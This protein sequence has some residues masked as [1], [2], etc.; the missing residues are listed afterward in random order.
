[1]KSIIAFYTRTGNTKKVAELIEKQ[2]NADTEE[3]IDKKN[4]SGFFGWLKSGYHATMGKTTEI[5]E[6][7]SD[8]SQYDIIIL[9]TPNWNK[10]MT[11]AIRTYINRF[12]EDFKNV[13]IYCTAEGRGVDSLLGD[14][15]E[16]IGKEPIAKMGFIKKD[17]EENVLDIKIKE[18]TEKIQ[19]SMKVD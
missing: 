17:A 19:N 5:G 8:P 6:L 15:K 4:R 11:P 10:R 9:G 18:F 12:K 2:L 3:I 1:M 16:L 14:L 13:A 7:K